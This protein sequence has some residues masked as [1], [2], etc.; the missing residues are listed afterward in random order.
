MIGLTPEDEHASPKEDRE[1]TKTFK[2]L[3]SP[4]P[5]TLDFDG[6]EV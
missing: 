6:L 1:D 2:Y 5:N 4:K 3:G